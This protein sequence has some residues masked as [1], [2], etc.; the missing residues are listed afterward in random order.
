MEEENC[1]RPGFNA[2]INV[3]ISHLMVLLH[4]WNRVVYFI[5]RPGSPKYVVVQYYRM[6]MITEIS[7]FCM[8]LKSWSTWIRFSTENSKQPKIQNVKRFQQRRIERKKKKHWFSPTFVPSLKTLE[9]GGFFLSTNLCVNRDT[10]WV[11]TCSLY[12]GLGVGGRLIRT[13]P[14]QYH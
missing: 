14:Y 7:K 1:K 6:T 10:N 5:I 13:K 4:C 12:L 8:K 9:I 3:I 2:F 11:A